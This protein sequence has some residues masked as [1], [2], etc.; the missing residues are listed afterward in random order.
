MGMIIMAAI[1]TTNDSITKSVP[2]LCIRNR[3]LDLDPPDDTI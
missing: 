1:A 3:L 2:S